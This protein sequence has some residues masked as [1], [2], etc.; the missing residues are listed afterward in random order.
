FQQGSQAAVEGTC[1]WLFKNESFRSWVSQD[2]NSLL[3]ITGVPGSGKTVLASF[4]VDSIRKDAIQSQSPAIVS[5]LFFDFRHS[6]K[7]ERGSAKGILLRALLYQLLDN[8]PSILSSFPGPCDRALRF[9]RPE[10]LDHNYYQ[11]CLNRALS[12]ATNTSTVFIVIDALDECDTDIQNDLL[13]CIKPIV[14]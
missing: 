6:L 9:E 11:R 3:W 13:A 5:S 4:L 12:A 14:S 10:D 7:R 8:D 1:K 2:R